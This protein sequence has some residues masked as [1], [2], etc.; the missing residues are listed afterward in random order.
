MLDNLHDSPKWV[1]GA[2]EEIVDI[3]K[4]YACDDD[5]RRAVRHAEGALRFSRDEETENKYSETQKK[6][7]TLQTELFEAWLELLKFQEE[8]CYD[9]VEEEEEDDDCERRC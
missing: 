4:S 5:L 2:L 6:F 8:H 1:T 7:A 9:S 3:V